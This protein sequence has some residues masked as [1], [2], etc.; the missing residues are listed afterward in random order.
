MIKIKNMS[1]L[2]S[3]DFSSRYLLNPPSVCAFISLACIPRGVRKP[4]R[5]H[6]CVYIGVR[7]RVKAPRSCV[8]ARMRGCVQ[9]ARD[10]QDDYSDI[11]VIVEGT[12]ARQ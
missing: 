12:I 1:V 8:H 7:A 6:A 9:R 4:F 3:A 11:V 2:V 5:L 10:A